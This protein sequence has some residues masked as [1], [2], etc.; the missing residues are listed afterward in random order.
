M[1]NKK[2]PFITFYA[3]LFALAI[4]LLSV[5]PHERLVYVAPLADVC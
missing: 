5:C 2:V 4:S 3:R 1:N